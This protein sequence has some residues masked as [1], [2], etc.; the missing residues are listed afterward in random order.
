MEYPAVRLLGT[1]EGEAHL[2]A[3]LGLSSIAAEPEPVYAR[4]LGDT[5]E[6]RPDGPWR[7]TVLVPRD[8][9]PA[10]KRMATWLMR[11]LL[12]TSTL[13]SEGNHPKEGDEVC[14]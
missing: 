8:N 9:R 3:E 2:D 6:M 11:P 5:V 14:A 12:R 7:L 1:P 4:P 13:P 10:Y